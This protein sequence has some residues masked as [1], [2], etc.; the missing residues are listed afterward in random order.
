MERIT[1][2]VL[3]EALGVLTLFAAWRVYVSGEPV[4][5]G[6]RAYRPNRQHNPI[7]FHFYLGVYV[8][9]GIAWTVWGTLIL[10]GLLRPLPSR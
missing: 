10:V 2:T 9:A 7:G 4:A 1:S 8:V 3:L 6:L 5:G